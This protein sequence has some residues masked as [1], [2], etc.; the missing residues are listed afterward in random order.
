MFNTVSE[1]FFLILGNRFQE[2]VHAKI[3]ISV[4]RKLNLKVKSSLDRMENV[5]SV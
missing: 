3:K 2:I 5:Q 4:F 1:I